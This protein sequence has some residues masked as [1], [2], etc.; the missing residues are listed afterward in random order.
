EKSVSALEEVMRT[1]RQIL[2]LTQTD[3]AED[4]PGFSDLYDV[5]TVANVMQLL[6]LPD[7]TVKVLVEGQE[8]AKVRDYYAEGEFH[9][10]GVEPLADERGDPEETAALMRAVIDQFREYVK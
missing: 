2:L 10:A 5:G 7:G 1:D 9:Q 6:K 8:R 3:P 4:E